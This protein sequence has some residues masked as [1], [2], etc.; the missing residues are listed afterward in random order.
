MT[1][2]FYSLLSAH[3]NKCTQSPSPI[4]PI[5]LPTFP[6]ATTSL[7]S[8]FKS[9]SSVCFFFSLF[10]YYVLAMRHVFCCFLCQS[11][12]YTVLKFKFYMNSSKFLIYKEWVL[13]FSFAASFPTPR[14]SYEANA[15]IM[16]FFFQMR[17]QKQWKIK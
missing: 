1:Q 9:V 5:L 12:S 7:F 10:A 16:S 11:I 6:L 14:Q 3:H 13:S 8:I 17:K 4:L 15:I 2:Q